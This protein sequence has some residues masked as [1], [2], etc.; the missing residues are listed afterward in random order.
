[1]YTSRY[2]NE[3]CRIYKI[4]IQHILNKMEYNIENGLLTISLKGNETHQERVNISKEIVQLYKDGKFTYPFK[5]L[6]GTVFPSFEDVKNFT[7]DYKEEDESMMIVGHYKLNI[8]TDKY[9]EEE[10][11]K[12]NLKYNIAPIDA[13]LD[14]KIVLKLLTGKGIITPYDMRER[15][16]EHV[17]EPTQFKI[18][19]AKAIID[20]HCKKGIC[21]DPCM[22]WGDRLIAALCSDIAKYIGF[23][24][25]THLENGYNSIIQ[26][27]NSTVQTELYIEPFSDKGYDNVD[28]VF[29]SPPFFDLEV[30]TNQE[31]QSIHNVKTYKEWLKVFYYPM[32]DVAW[33]SLKKGGK[34]ILYIGDT[35]CT[36][37]FV[38]DTIDYIQGGTYQQIFLSK[39]M[40]FEMWTKNI[41]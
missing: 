6:N 36:P 20:G 3:R 15:L 24:P 30:Y 32:L 23:D 27:A 18:S 8:L 37:T 40:S 4:C 34:L 11:L 19:I 26:D 41:L 22:G 9:S 21:M 17:R 7:H 28:L 2:N 5:K 31:T 25:N 29:T 10:R 33:Q 39:R 38:K 12:A 1:M 14:H 16:Y 35:K 13:L